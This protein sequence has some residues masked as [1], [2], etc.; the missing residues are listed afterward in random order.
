MKKE[1]QQYFEKNPSTKHHFYK[2]VFKFLNKEYFFKTDS[3]VFSKK[4][5]DY[6]TQVLLKTIYKNYQIIPHGNIL[7]L[8]TGYGPIGIIFKSL[9]PDRSIYMCDINYRALNLAKINL[10]INR[11]QA[12]V[13]YSDVYASVKNKFAS[14]ITNPPIRAGKKIVNT[15]LIYS[16]E[17]LVPG[18]TIFAV[19]QKKQ[20]AQS[21]KKILEKRF[22]NCKIMN[23][24][25][26]YYVLRS[27]KNF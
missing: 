12:K 18:G 27:I 26:G 17:Y 19:I 10:N 4:Y 8:G 9:Y 23:R 22:G 3:N 11:L 6:G 15:I 5:I 2:F 16:H 13:F 20:G 24:D 21:A 1:N 14:I 25:K 7:D